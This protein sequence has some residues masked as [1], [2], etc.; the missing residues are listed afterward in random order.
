MLRVGLGL[1]LS[2]FVVLGGLFVWANWIFPHLR[3]NWAFEHLFIEP[4][5]VFVAKTEQHGF[6]YPKIPYSAKAIVRGENLQLQPYLRP[7]EEG[8][9]EF[10]KTFSACRDFVKA[11]PDAK[12][13]T[14]S[15]EEAHF[16]T[17][18]RF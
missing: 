7:A 1:L 5:A 13:Y 15:L 17:Y 8:L 10:T 12:L 3:P 18:N 6:F 14:G 4:R 2:P 9:Q 16:F 11:H